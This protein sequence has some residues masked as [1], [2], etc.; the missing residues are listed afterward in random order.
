MSGETRNEAADARRRYFCPMHPDV[1]QQSPGSCPKCGMALHEQHGDRGMRMHQKEEAMAGPEDHTKMVIQMR[2]PWLWTNFTVMLLGLCLVSSPFTFGYSAGPMMVS[3]VVSGILLILFAGL[4]LFPARDF[5]GR[6][7]VA[8]VGTWL[9]FAPLI[10]WAPTPAAMVNDTFIGALAIALSIL[11]PMMPG[12][13][14][15]M[16]M[17][18]PGPRY[19][20]GG[21]IILP[22]GTSALR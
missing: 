16:E 15:H 11:V 6:W 8:L 3:D 1:Q 21:P 7:S 22:V 14:H 9:Q 2:A 13:A 12:M 19:L 5:M 18:K 17:L 4:A 10:F 20:R